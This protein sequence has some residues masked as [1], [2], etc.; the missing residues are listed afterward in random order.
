MEVSQFIVQHK[1][2]ARFRRCHCCSSGESRSLE[3]VEAPGLVLVVT[4]RQQRTLGVQPCD[5]SSL[6]QGTPTLKQ[7]NA[8]LIKGLLI[9]G[10]G[11]N[12]M[13]HLQLILMLDAAENS[14]SVD[15]LNT[16]H[17]FISI[18]PIIG[19]SSAS[20]QLEHRWRCFALHTRRVAAST[21]AVTSVAH[22]TGSVPS[23]QTRMYTCVWGFE[24]MFAK[25]R[26]C[27]H[28]TLKA[29]RYMLETLDT[30]RERETKLWRARD[31][32]ARSVTSNGHGRSTQASQSVYHLTY[33]KVAQDEDHLAKISS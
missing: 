20:P 30:Q 22:P 11:L 14:K 28:G 31:R 33:D 3:C 15:L 7:A 18:S 2:V 9:M 29:A 6:S 27:G 4:S 32:L 19:F 21:R 26:S 10:G 8:C 25:G 5:H 23:S 1:R 16:H 13:P 17:Y 12:F 24:P